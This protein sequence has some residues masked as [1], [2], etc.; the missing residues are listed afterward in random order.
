MRAHCQHIPKQEEW[1]F[2]K[3]GIF[4]VQKEKVVHF[5]QKNEQNVK[6]AIAICEKSW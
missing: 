6:K 4:F 2:I 5:H 1:H 3:N